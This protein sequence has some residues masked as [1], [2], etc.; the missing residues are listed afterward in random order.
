MQSCSCPF[1][2]IQ[3]H[4]NC[5]HHRQL[6][7]S[8]LPLREEKMNRKDT[9]KEAIHV[10]DSLETIRLPEFGVKSAQYTKREK[11]CKHCG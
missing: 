2:L 7:L 4:H 6:F 5:Y 9:L 8:C 3:V 1:L 10:K 11:F